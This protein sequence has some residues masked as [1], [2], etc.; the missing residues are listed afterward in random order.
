M[1]NHLSGGHIVAPPTKEWYEK[2][3]KMLQNMKPGEE[4][5]IGKKVNPSRREHFTELCKLYM[6]G[7]NRRKHQEWVFS[8]DML[9]FKRIR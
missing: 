7:C 6:Q 5:N 3:E 9:K 1:E 8:E 4:F 2:A